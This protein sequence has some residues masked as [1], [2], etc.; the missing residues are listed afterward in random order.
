MQTKQ[1]TAPSRPKQA[2]IDVNYV[3]LPDLQALARAAHLRS[4]EDPKYDRLAG[5]LAI[6]FLELYEITH[7]R[8]REKDIESA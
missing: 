6:A 5:Q 8:V 4:L 2:K 3:N 1:A 7:G